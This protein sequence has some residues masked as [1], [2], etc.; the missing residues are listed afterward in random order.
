M[1][2]VTNRV[3]GERNMIDFVYRRVS[4]DNQLKE[5]FH[6]HRGMEILMI[7]QGRGT[8][9]VNQVSYAIEPGML[10]IF[11]PYQLHHVQ[12]DYA[13]NQS[14]ERSLVTFEPT[15]FEAFFQKWPALHSFY[16]HLCLSKLAAPCIYGVEETG[17]L[18]ASFRSMYHKLQHASDA[19]QL[20]EYSLFLVMLFRALKPLWQNQQKQT[21]PFRT[22]KHHQVE[23]ILAW[24]ERHYTVPF[25]LRHLAAELHLSPYHLSH[26]FKKAVGLSITEY[27]AV[28][29][30][31][32]A[33]LLLTTTDKPITWIAE[34][35]GLTNSS[36]FCKFFKARMG[37][38]PH[39]YRKRWTTAP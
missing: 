9:I 13:D 19:E 3:R 10:C 39:Q 17:E 12:L 31:H 23:H 5:T 25:D 22:R 24:I 27:I 4:V 33:V 16:R 37:A 26:L 8:M 38:T 32:Q 35:I 30:M 21:A 18:V 29:R 6:S 2:I 36:Y 14:F 7:H 11:Q 34:E 15:L 28:R 1:A 20:E